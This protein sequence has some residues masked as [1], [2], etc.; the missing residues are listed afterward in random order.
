[1]YRDVDGR[2][3][4][5]DEWVKAWEAH[6]R[7]AETVLLDGKVVSTVWLG[8]DHARDGRPL[9]FET[10]VFPSRED[11]TDLDVGRYSSRDE[12]LAGHEAM[13]EKWIR[14]MVDARRR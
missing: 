4:S 12:A 1:M 8:L 5:R 10:M 2:P 14:A 13:V 11:F 3:I 9:I 6:R 7:Q